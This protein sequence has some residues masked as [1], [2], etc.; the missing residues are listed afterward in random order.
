MDNSIKS[1]APVAHSLE[2][3]GLGSIQVQNADELRL[4][5]MGHRQ[6]LKRHFSV[7]S[8]IGLAAN[9]TIS[10][11]GLGLGLIT[12]INAGGP[13]ALIY[14]FI[15]V[16][17]LQCFLGTS[18]A[19]FVSAYPVEG[20]MYH[21]IAA[22]APKRYS[23]VLSFATGWSTVF[24]W[25]FTTASTNLVYSSN[26]IALIALYRPNLVVQPWMTFVAYQGFNVITSGIVMFGNKWMPAINKFSLCYL[27]L[28]WFA[29]LVTVAAT[30][31]KHNDAEFVF[32]T[33]INETGWKNNVVCFI[34]GLV[35]P[36]YSLG[37]LD[38]ITHI[39]EEMPNPGRNAPLALACT[40]AIAF[41]TGLTYLLSLM[42][43][44]QD[45]A[46][47]ADSPTG[48]PLAE[49][50]RQ[51]TQSR[52]GAFALVFLLWVAVGPCVIGSQLS[53]GRMLWAFARDDGLP[54]SKFCSKVNK[55]FGAPVNA[56][57]CVGIIIA[58]LGC[59]YLGSSTAFNSMMSSAVTINNIA[60]LVPI[61]T[62]VLL[63]RK[64]MHRGPFS[65]G[66]VA[67]MTVNIITVAW[68]IFAIV[69]FSFPYDM[70]VT[71]S[72]M[73]YTCVCVGGFLLLELL[74]WIVAG[75]KYSRRMEKV[76]EEEKNASQAVVVDLVGKS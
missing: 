9:C 16:F 46:S 7:W 68:L 28:A 5:Q 56:Q 73:N 1:A 53:T 64:T 14:G 40:L 15:F 21:W 27:Q 48:L 25:I 26:F 30:A 63:G 37:G 59:I 61:L 72:N 52:G 71:A 65:L 74:W 11:T 29:I 13:G 51:A 76:R 36:L 22:I 70:P 45:Y 8:L 54:F 17:I 3:R 34:T 75:K 33:W 2:D 69:F 19:E 41:V 44:V 66:Y 18:L 4:A 32:R 35:N 12:S 23:N 67:G 43:S 24:G 38:G 20:G 50:F 6:E 31:P 60:Y 58:L 39:T 62:N 10:W 57:L 47:L 49:L 55:R 42:F